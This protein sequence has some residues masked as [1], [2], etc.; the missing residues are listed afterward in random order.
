MRSPTVVSSHPLV[1]RSIGFGALLLAMSIGAPSPSSAQASPHPFYVGGGAGVAIEL[2][3]YPTQFVLAEEVGYHLFGTN[4]GLF[5]GGAFAQGFG[6]DVVTLQLG[7][8]IGYDIALYDGPD[9]AVMLAPSVAPGVV[10]AFASVNTP[11]GRVSG[12]DA[13][14]DFQGA[15]DVKLLLLDGALEVFLRPAAVDVF[16]GDGVAV[17]WNV[18][19]GA[20]ARF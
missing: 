18:L 6:R 7:A 16:V 3:S 19:G 2:D 13:A 14:F 17:R 1:R 8:R 9:L 15:L 4:G 12:D 10:I 5:L 11:F 20:A